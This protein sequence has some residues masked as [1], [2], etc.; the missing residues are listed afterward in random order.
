MFLRKI[1]LKKLFL[2]INIWIYQL[3]FVYLCR[4]KLNNYDKHS[5]KL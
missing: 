1:L 3:F 5:K 2:K 4:K